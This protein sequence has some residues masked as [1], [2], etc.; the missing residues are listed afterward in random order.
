MCEALSTSLESIAEVQGFPAG[1]GDTAGLLRFLHP[2][3]V[4]VDS[5]EEAVEAAKFARDKGL[6]V[7][8]VSLP[9]RKIRLLRHGRWERLK[10][11]DASAETIRNVIVGGI[12]GRNH[13]R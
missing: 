3:A 9:E 6:P 1:R 5:D 12:F 8:H 13:A 4:V 10:N 7:V 11:G 2:D